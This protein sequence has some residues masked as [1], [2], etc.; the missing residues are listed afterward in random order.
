MK[1]DPS[2]ALYGQNRLE[3][4]LNLNP[5]EGFCYSPHL[6]MACISML[7]CN[8]GCCRASPY[9]LLSLEAA[10]ESVAQRCCK[11]TYDRQ[12]LRM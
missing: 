2:I 11:H 9:P 3:F 8:H 10:H 6:Q 7:G 12:Y 5:S 1:S 4:Y